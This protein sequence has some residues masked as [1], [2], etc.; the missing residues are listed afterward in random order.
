MLTT[1]WV[2]AGVSMAGG[3]WAVITMSQ[4][5]RLDAKNSLT[6]WLVALFAF[7]LT[8]PDSPAPPFT[9]GGNLGVGILMS[10]GLW[11]IAARLSEVKLAALLP[12][13]APGLVM[14]L[15]PAG[16]QPILS[17]IFIGTS[18]VWCCLGAQWSALA[19][20]QIAF[21]SAIGMVFQAAAPKG[22]IPEVWHLEPLWIALS[23]AF[24]MAILLVTRRNL[25]GSEWLGNHAVLCLGLGLSVALAAFLCGDRD[26]WQLALATAGATTLVGLGGND[27]ESR[28]PV[29]VWIGLFAFVFSTDRGYGVAVVAL[30]VG[31]YTAALAVTEAKVCLE[32]FLTGSALLTMAALFRLF[33]ETYPLR[34]PRADLYTHTALLGF[35][36]AIAVLANLASWQGSLLRKLNGGFWA[37][38]SPLALGAIWGVRSVAGWMGGSLAV[39]LTLLVLPLP[40]RGNLPQ[41]TLPLAFTGMA[42][43]LPLT[44]LVDPLSDA[45]RLSRIWVLLII[46][47]LLLASLLLEWFTS[48][49]R[50]VSSLVDAE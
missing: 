48:R 39:V 45:P 1:A 6:T 30:M 4:G 41:S 23:V 12:L 7:V 40:N 24:S 50:P 33:V 35:L 8:L 21:C 16:P 26:L 29:L 15:V 2:I 31:L 36:L 11:L 28:L 18:I 42:A 13:L 25:E 10:T 47:G 17:G 5:Q 34:T 46:G 22:V 32:N 49:Q 20:A 14:L 27:Q 9:A 37:A 3:L 44:A 19:L 38:A 43:A